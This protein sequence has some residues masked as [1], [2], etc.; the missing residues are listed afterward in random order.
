MRRIAVVFLL[1]LLRTG[2]GSAASREDPKPVLAAMNKAAASVKSA[3]AD[4]DW[5]SYNKLV[6]EEK[7]VQ[8]GKI[9]FRR[10]GDD[11]DVALHIESP[12]P[13]RVVYH[14]GLIRIYE[15]KIRQLTKREVGN[16]QAAKDAMISLGFG[17]NGDELAKAFE[18]A[19]DGSQDGSQNGWE[20]VDK[21]KTAKLELVPRIPS[22]KKLFSKATLWVDP[23]RGVPLQQQFFAPSGDYELARYA[24]IKV[25]APVS[26]EDFIANPEDLKPVLA[27]M[28]QASANFKSAKAD[29]EWTNYTKL[30][31]EKDVQNGR[32]FFRR[33]GSDVDVALHIESPGAKQVVY[34]KGVV[35]MYEPKIDQ[36]TVREVGKNKAD[37]DAVISLGFGGNGDELARDFEV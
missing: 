15:P 34:Q 2:A 13:K 29:C 1:C 16:N 14:K 35:R 11:V 20:T 9:F 5:V 27:A 3:K 32:I 31:D 30:V 19:L 25:N 22:L 10:G 6:N 28:N 8:R 37:L 4:F 12:V 21:I 7:E 18:V 26:D 36:L 33:A 24:N 23:V 17:G